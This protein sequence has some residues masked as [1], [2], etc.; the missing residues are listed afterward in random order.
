MKKNFTAKFTNAVDP[1]VPMSVWGKGCA[2]KDEPIS[3]ANKYKSTK[4]END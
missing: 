4:K 1:A 3:K 2:G